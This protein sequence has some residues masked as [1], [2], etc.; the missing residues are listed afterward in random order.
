LATADDLHIT[1]YSMTSSI[2]L[3][4]LVLLP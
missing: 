2:L 1:P 4:A 3:L